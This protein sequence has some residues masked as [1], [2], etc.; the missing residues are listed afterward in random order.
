[1]QT[2]HSVTSSSPVRINAALQ[3]EWILVEFSEVP[4]RSCE[5]RGIKPSNK[6]APTCGEDGGGIGHPQRTETQ[7]APSSAAFSSPV[8]WSNIPTAD[9]SLPPIG[10]CVSQRLCVACKLLFRESCYLLFYVSPLFP[11]VIPSV[12]PSL[13]PSSPPLP[14]LSACLDLALPLSF[15]S[16]KGV[17]VHS[18]AVWHHSRISSAVLPLHI[19]LICC[20]FPSIIHLEGSCYPF[21]LCLCTRFSC[22]APP[23]FMYFALFFLHSAFR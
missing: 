13:S 19:F 11:R 1:M 16:P 8:S 22:F 17:C 6:A 14:L 5:N 10:V 4:E 12:L 9:A 2:F 18:A 7:S 23:S 20:R 15:S 3:S 21:H